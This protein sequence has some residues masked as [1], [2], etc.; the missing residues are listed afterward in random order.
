MNQVY[1]IR[2]DFCGQQL[3]FWHTQDNEGN[4]VIYVQ[5]CTECS[6]RKIDGRTINRWQVVNEGQ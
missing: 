4:A 1:D 5:P 3:N 6:R 2:C